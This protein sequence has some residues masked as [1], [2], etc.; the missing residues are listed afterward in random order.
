MERRGNIEEEVW[1]REI[2]EK[3]E[4]WNDVF[5]EMN[6]SK[7]VPR[8]SVVPRIERGSKKLIIVPRKLALFHME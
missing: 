8:E 3:F 1:G 4:V 5:Q 6:G 2:Q 7:M